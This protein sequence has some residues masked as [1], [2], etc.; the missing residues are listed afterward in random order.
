MAAKKENQIDFFDVDGFCTPRDPDAPKKRSDCLKSRPCPFVACR[1]NL[2]LDVLEN[3][4]IKFN[5]KG[6]SP[7]EV[8]P[9][10]SCVFDCIK[11]QQGLTFREIAKLLGGVSRERIR[12]I[13]DKAIEHLEAKRDSGELFKLFDFWCE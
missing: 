7:L 1:Y 4:S 9:D 6:K 13:N 2:Y 5:H 10:Q 12:Q 11:D 8:P 3:G